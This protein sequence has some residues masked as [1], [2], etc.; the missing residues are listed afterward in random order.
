MYLSPLILFTDAT[1][2]FLGVSVISVIR[3]QWLRL[4]YL[5]EISERSITK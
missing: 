5:Y 1:D 3:D 4:Q 2:S